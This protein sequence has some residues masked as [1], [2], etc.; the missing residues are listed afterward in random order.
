ML[1]LVVCIKQVP[2]VSELPWDSKRGTLKREL[3]DGMMNPTCKHALEAALSLKN[4]FGGTITAVSMGPPMAEEVLREAVAMGADRGILLSDP[5]IAGADTLATSSAIARLIEK[6]CSDFD[7]VF[8]GCN[9]IDSET[10]QVAPQLTEE[11]DI[12]GV[13]YVDEFELRDNMLTVQRT[14]DGFLET[15]MLELPGLISVTTRHFIPRFASFSGLQDAFAQIEIEQYGAD[16]IGLLPENAGQKGSPTKILDVYSP[17]TNKKNMVLSGSPRKIV[18]ELFNRFDDKI[19][20]A[21][22]KDLKEYE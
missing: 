18:E 1:K 2:M 5:M 11:L 12:P 15:L 10:A 19:G 14:V 6:E 21:I 9:T 16:H 3:A 4:R 17:T 7:L 20:S 22:G 13:M 8:C